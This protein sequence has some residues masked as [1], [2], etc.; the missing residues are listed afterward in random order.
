MESDQKEEEI[1]KECELKI[2]RLF[3]FIF[4]HD[5]NDKVKKKSCRLTDSI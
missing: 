4:D 3:Q 2:N 1:I 5:G